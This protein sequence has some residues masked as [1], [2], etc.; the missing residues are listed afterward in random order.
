[1]NGE[2]RPAMCKRA[3]G[4]DPI[5]AR[6]L[7]ALHGA[8]GGCVS[9]A[10]LAAKL[11]VSR[12]TVWK[13]VERLKR[14]GYVID[15]VP[16]GGY[17]L[18][19]SA[20]VLLA[21]EIERDLGC[22]R[23]GR[24]VE[25]YSVLGSTND[26][27]LELG[28]EGAPEG[29]VVVAERQTKG[30]GRLGRTWESPPGVGIWCSVLVRPNLAPRYAP[31]LTLS[32]AV[33]VITVLESEAGVSPRIKWPND[34]LVDDKKLCGILTE[35]VAEQDRIEYAVVGI[36]LNVN[37]TV[38]DLPSIVRDTASSVRIVTGRRF[39]RM[40]LLRALLEL[41]ERDYYH[42]LEQGF[43]VTRSRWMDYS[44]TMGRTVRCEWN[45]TV[46]SGQA[47]GLGDEGALLIREADGRVV[48]VVRG[49]VTVL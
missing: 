1:V 32:A 40:A 13:H 21:A 10:V 17:Q 31:W 19:E 22:T 14:L 27:A 5:D 36:G 25:S 3:Y 35:L 39:S 23:F 18:V 28:R 20:D 26:V 6:L 41:L 49:N 7:D 16:F 29:T 9:G 34:V 37:Q 43:E 12:T 24:P 38:D 47:V 11:G 4:H 8:G 15:T 30:R 44:A 42:M 33:S 48:P 46:V 45:D 2:A